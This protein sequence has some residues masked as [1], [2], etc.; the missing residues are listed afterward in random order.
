MCHNFRAITQ[1]FRQLWLLKGNQHLSSLLCCASSNKHAQGSRAEL[2]CISREWIWMI[3][4]RSQW[5]FSLSLQHC[6]Q[7]RSLIRMR[8]KCPHAPM[9]SLC[10]QYPSDRSPPSELSLLK[11]C[12]MFQA[13]ATCIILLICSNII[14]YNAISSCIRNIQS[15]YC[16]KKIWKN[17][18]FKWNQRSLTLFSLTETMIVAKQPKCICQCKKYLKPW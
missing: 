10:H 11:F 5:L 3:R 15:T 18:F 17:V 9:K 7:S 2:T 16:E 8:M 1:H 12:S 6:L 14:D 13:A 4:L